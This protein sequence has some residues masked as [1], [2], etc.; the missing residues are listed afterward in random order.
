MFPQ[1]LGSALT[2]ERSSFCQRLSEL[3]SVYPWLPHVA[4]GWPANGRVNAEPLVRQV[5]QY[6]AILLVEPIGQMHNV[7]ILPNSVQA[8]WQLDLAAVLNV[9]TRERGKQIIT[10]TLALH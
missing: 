9:N 8:R 6:S 5:G 1:R 4:N 10:L 7:R 2:R 3:V